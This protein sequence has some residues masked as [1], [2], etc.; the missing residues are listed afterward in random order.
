MA[1]NILVVDD[2]LPMR[3]VIKKTIKASGFSMAQY[4]EAS[5]GAEALKILN[6]KWIDIVVTDYNMPNMNGLELVSEMKKNDLLKTIPVLVITTEGGKARVAE[7]KEKGVSGY[8]KKPF[9]PEEIRLKLNEI[10]GDP[11]NDEGT[12]ISDDS[13]DF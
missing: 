5:D 4:E 6:E 1:F 9:T 11:G 3:K 13:L 8:I 2:S 12:E 10:L 7:F